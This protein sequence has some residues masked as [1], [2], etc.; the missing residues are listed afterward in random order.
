MIFFLFC[1]CFQAASIYFKSESE[2]QLEKIGLNPLDH[3]L[4]AFQRDAKIQLLRKHFGSWKRE[5]TFKKDL[6]K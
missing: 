4:S 3:V 5:V 1:S 2:K 6:V